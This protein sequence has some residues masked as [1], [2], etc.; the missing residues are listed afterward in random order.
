M[1]ENVPDDPADAN[2]SER[3]IAERDAQ[4]R[5]S[6]SPPA[7]NDGTVNKIDKAEAPETALLD[8]G[9]RRWL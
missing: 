2:E 8:F 3:S 1:S 9:R 7:E 5:V 6:P 4:P